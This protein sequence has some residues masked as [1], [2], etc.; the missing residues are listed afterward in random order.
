M[1]RFSLLFRTLCMATALSMPT[2]SFSAIDLMPKEA[3]VDANVV[4]VQVVNNGD[5]PEYVSISLSR[6]L[7]PGVPLPNLNP[8]QAMV[9]DLVRVR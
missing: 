3:T 8:Q 9:F 7:N 6:L 2:V 5:R 1:K 4:T